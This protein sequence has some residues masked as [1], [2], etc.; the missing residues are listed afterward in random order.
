MGGIY[1]KPC[2]GYYQFLRLKKMRLLKA[3]GNIYKGM[4]ENNVKL[5]K[6]GLKNL[7]KEIQIFEKNSKV[8]KGGEHHGVL[9]ETIP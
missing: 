5:E 4:E 7:L 1:Q 6:V 3:M 9:A 8:R 2:R